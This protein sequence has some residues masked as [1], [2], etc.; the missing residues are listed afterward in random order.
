MKNVLH[1]PKL[2]C[3]LVTISKLSKKLNC[4]VTYFDDFCV[5][6]DRTSR[7][8][9]EAGEQRERFCY[10]KRPTSNQVNAVKTR[11]LWHKRLGHPS[12]DVISMLSHSLGAN[13]G[14]NK[15]KDELC[16]ICLR[17]KQT[18]N[19]FPISQSIAKNVFD[20]VHCDI[21]GPYETPSSCG[22]HYFLSIIDDASRELGSI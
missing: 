4:A 1:L 10:Y 7:S 3:N 21:W 13:C 15:I 16:E 6:H 11:C 12:N 20:L 9:I 19:K 14:L 5:I 2:N 22:A 18:R 17:A 8:L